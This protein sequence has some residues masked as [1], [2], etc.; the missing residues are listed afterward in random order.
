MFV[1]NFITSSL[2]QFLMTSSKFTEHFPGL[3]NRDKST[4]ICRLVQIIEWNSEYEGKHHTFW[5]AHLPLSNT[6]KEICPGY[7]VGF[8]T[9]W[10]SFSIWIMLSVFID[11]KKSLVVQFFTIKILVTETFGL[12]RQLKY[13]LVI[14][15]MEFLWVCYNAISQ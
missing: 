13:F 4:G 7:N 11:Q 2:F 12:G 10:Q 6:R 3:N 5:S 9:K 1:Q 14:F 15:H 8:M